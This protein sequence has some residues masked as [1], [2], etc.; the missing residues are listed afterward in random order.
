MSKLL[1]LHGSA[2]YHHQIG[3]AFLITNLNNYFNNK[4]KKY[5]ATSETRIDYL[6]KKDKKFNIPDVIVWDYSNPINS[7]LWIESTTKRDLKKNITK[8]KNAFKYLKKL[9]E[10]F[11]YEYQSGV[12]YK[13]ERNSKKEIKDSKSDFLKLDLSKLIAKVV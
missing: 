11:V 9:E 5:I 6:I 12:F 13:L 4:K 10:A 7:V 8:S 1:G 2:N 3:L